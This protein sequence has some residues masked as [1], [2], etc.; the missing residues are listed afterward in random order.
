[1]RCILSIDKWDF[2]HGGNL[3]EQDCTFPIESLWCSPTNQSSSAKENWLS[4]N[5]QNISRIGVQHKLFD[6]SIN[7][8]I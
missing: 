7:Q 6:Q 5:R 3:F 4:R 1:M 8:L 2:K